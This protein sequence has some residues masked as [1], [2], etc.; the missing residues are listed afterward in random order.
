MIVDDWFRA[1]VP[2]LPK[3]SNL[4]HTNP[5]LLL[6]SLSAVGPTSIKTGYCLPALLSS[7]LNTSAMR[8]SSCSYFWQVNTVNLCI[9]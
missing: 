5:L 6:L 3:R 4:N 9:V 7:H 2:I 8:S 1:C